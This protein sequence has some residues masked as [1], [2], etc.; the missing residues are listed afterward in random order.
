MYFD[1][2]LPPT[3]KQVVA[4]ILPRNP[5]D[6]KHTGRSESGG[7]KYYYRASTELLLY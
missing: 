5:S 3:H 2:F 7:I 6:N 4:A 1:L